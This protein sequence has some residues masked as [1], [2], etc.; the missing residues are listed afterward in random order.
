MQYS[1]PH[2]ITW[3]SSDGVESHPDS[4]IHPH[5]Q[6]MDCSRGKSPACTFSLP[7]PAPS[8]GSWQ[9]FCK[10]CRHLQNINA[11]GRNDDPKSYRVECGKIKES[12]V[13]IKRQM[14]LSI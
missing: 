7:Y 14:E 9:V 8:V 11:N 12:S 5:G 10:S 1:S 2:T 3:K 13:V 6:I 4:G